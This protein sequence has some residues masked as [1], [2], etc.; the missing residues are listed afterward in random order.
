MS[1]LVES[2]RSMLIAKNLPKLLW[3]EAIKTAYVLNRT[4]STQLNSKTAYEK[5]F[6]RKPVI[7]QCE[8][9]DVMH[10]KIIQKK[11]KRKWK[12]R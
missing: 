4:I 11:K 3:A 8:C 9:L 5:W 1:T 10:I 7:K 12:K 6:K 2:A